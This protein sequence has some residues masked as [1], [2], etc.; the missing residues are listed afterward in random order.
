LYSSGANRR[1]AEGIWHVVP[2]NA[3]STQAKPPSF[4]LSMRVTFNR[5]PVGPAGTILTGAVSSSTDCM[6]APQPSW[7]TSSRVG[8]PGTWNRGHGCR[9]LTAR[10]DEALATLSD[11][12]ALTGN[13][14]ISRHVVRVR[15]G[16]FNCRQR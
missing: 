4:F 5:N 7:P 14:A 2:L 12:V 13:P 8:S 15:V 10:I 1:M 11:L 9:T 6:R 3:H 16:A